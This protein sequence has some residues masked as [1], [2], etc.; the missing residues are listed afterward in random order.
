MLLLLLLFYIA[1]IYLS[2]FTYWPTYFILWKRIFLNKEKPFN[3]LFKIKASYFLIKHLLVT[4][5]LTFF[6]YLDE[7]LFLGYKKLNIN[8]VFI[9]GQPRSGT[10]FLHRTLAKDTKNFFAIRHLEWRYPFISIQLLIKLLKLSSILKKISY[11]PNNDI[12]RKAEKMHSNNMLDW[13]E[14]GIFY[15]ERILHHF[16]IFLRFPYPDLLSYLDDFTKLPTNTQNHIL[17]THKKVIQRIMYL[18]GG[19]EQQYLS[20]EVTSHSKIP[21]LLELYPNA[22][23]ILI[24]RPS[25]DFMSSLLSLIRT[26]THVKTGFDPDQIEGW[27]ACILQRMRNDSQYLVNLCKKQISHD[28]QIRIQFNQF[29]KDPKTNIQRI[30][31]QLGKRPETSYYHYID[32]IAQK[33][34]TRESGYSYQKQKF[35]GFEQFDDFVSNL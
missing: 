4:P 25:A 22:Q 5:F 30:Y 28:K 21:K 17:K 27:E 34:K 16:F 2:P 26:S 1:G 23:F 7:I 20:K 12:G 14:D 15:E 29:V 32:K 13:E 8:P 24:L 18:R 6:W 9:I 3:T 35:Q 31:T 19:T 11:W 10:T 33:Q